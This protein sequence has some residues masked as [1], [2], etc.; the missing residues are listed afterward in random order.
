MGIIAG[1][2]GERQGCLL[3]HSFKIAP[4]QGRG[5]QKT[6]E[7]ETLIWGDGVVDCKSAAGRPPPPPRILQPVDL[8]PDRSLGN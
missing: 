1:L 3:T 7:S 5:L 4:R 8:C 2:G 6:D